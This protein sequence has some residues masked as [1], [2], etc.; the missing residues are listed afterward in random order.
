V[1]RGTYAYADLASCNVPVSRGEI[2][3]PTS[4]KC[5]HR[6]SYPSTAELPSV[7]SVASLGICHRNGKAS[8]QPGRTSGA[9][10]R[11]CS[12]F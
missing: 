9:E 3:Q 10:K 11:R 2:H 8:S 1:N 7:P 12:R 5:A 6:S 4:D